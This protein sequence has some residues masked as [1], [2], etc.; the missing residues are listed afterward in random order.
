MCSSD[1]NYYIIW[2]L[3][4]F[5]IKLEKNKKKLIETVLLERKF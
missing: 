4:L 1:L 2:E 3:I 5:I